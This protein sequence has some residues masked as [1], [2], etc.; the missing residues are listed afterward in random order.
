MPTL[1]TPSFRSGEAGHRTNQH[2]KAFR[3]RNADGSSAS[4]DDVARAK[5]LVIPPASADV[6]ICAGRRWRGG[7]TSASG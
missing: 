1:D 5:A 6:W 2:D 7:P 3:Y 4:P